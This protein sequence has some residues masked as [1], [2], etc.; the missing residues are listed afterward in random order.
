MDTVALAT[1]RRTLILDLAQA[2][3]GSSY[4]LNHTWSV[5]TSKNKDGK[6]V[7]HV[8]VYELPNGSLQSWK[9]LM[10][11]SRGSRI[12]ASAGEYLLEELRGMLGERVA[13]LEEGIGGGGREKAEWNV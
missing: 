13:G 11:G 2:L 1:H 7:A 10:S 3:F 6:Y 5:L 12:E 9:V 8:I 4:P